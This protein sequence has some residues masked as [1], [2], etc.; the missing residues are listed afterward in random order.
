[1]GDEKDKSK[2]KN[3]ET[4]ETENRTQPI[5]IDV[6]DESKKTPKK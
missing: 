2:D 3:A 1:M 4:E 5:E 6:H